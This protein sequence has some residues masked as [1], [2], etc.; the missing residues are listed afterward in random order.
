MANTEKF[1]FI[2]LLHDF[3]HINFSFEK[4]NATFDP[5]SSSYRESIVFLS[6]LPVIFILLIIIL[7]ACCLCALC[8]KKQPQKAVKTT[9]LR[10]F[11]AIFIIFTIGSAAVGFFANQHTNSGVNSF[12][13]SVNDANQ[14]LEDTYSTLNILN[15]T[16]VRI[17]S[18]GVNGILNVIRSRI[19]NTTAV[20]LLENLMEK[21]EQDSDS[22]R[23]ILK[24]IK[25]KVPR[26]DLTNVST[27][28]KEIEFYRWCGTI[29]LLCFVLFLMILAIVGCYKK[30]RCFLLMAT[31]IGYLVLLLVWIAS[32]V[33]LGTAVAGGDLCD[34]PD[35]FIESLGSNSAQ[36]TVIKAYLDCEVGK[37]LPSNF[38]AN[39][40]DA[41]KAVYEAN[42]T[43]NHVINKTLPFNIQNELKQPVLYIRGELDY[44]LGNITTLS[45]LLD[46]KSFHNDYTD[47]KTSV[48]ETTLIG[49]VLLLLVVPFMGLCMVFIQCLLPRIWHLSAKR[50]GYR[51]VDDTDPFSPRPP[52]YNGYGSMHAGRT[53]NADYYGE[54]RHSINDSHS[55]DV[56][57]HELPRNESPPPAVSMSYFPLSSQFVSLFQHSYR[58]WQLGDPP[59]ERPPF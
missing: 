14:S 45:E 11:A 48:C 52:P 58:S 15:Q 53:S 10:I 12:V 41:N 6:A 26:T 51:P 25:D 2:T 24:E 55:V 5:S 39:V 17:Q 46:C 1:W 34:S 33:Y 8:V 30:S 59:Y 42:T 3:P 7:S 57:T 23:K 38:S 37:G 47:V 50:R 29:V 22:T 9:C 21:I 4:T 31:C 44:A 27:R 56:L 20:N 18:K 28:T 49:I 19:Q 43:L 36:K 16:A 54:P 40:K 13:N 35:G 32:G